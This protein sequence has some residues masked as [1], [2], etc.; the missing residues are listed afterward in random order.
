MAIP[1]NTI[2]YFLGS[3]ATLVVGI[4]SLQI[5][6]KIK[7]PLSKHFAISGFLAAI[8]LG[9]YSVPFYLTN[10]PKILKICIIFGR[11]FVD[12]VGYWQFY[13]I[14]YLTSLKKY[15][16]RYFVIPL[17]IVAVIGFIN[18]AIYFYNN[19]AGVIDGLAVYRFTELAGY[20]HLLALLI[21][22][23]AGIIISI[24]AFKQTELRAKIRL[25]S[26]AIL[27]IFAS[28]ADIYNTIFLQGSSNSW[29]VLVGFIIAAGV[30]LITSLIFSRK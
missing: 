23:I 15:K 21:V 5:Y 1:T 9:L 20:I 7:G 6:Q 22:F 13:L 18:Q 27:Y 11:L 8:G 19:P 24:N 14:W 29:V 25:L 10:D 30:F 16:L 26:I 2:P 12:I 3:I 28:L 17:F 4:K